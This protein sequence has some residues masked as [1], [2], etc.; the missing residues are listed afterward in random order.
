M[1]VSVTTSRCS[2]PQSTAESK[3]E[4]F[5]II[6]CHRSFVLVRNYL[7][8]INYTGPIGL[9]CD[10][11]KLFAA[12]RPYWNAEEGSHYVVG[13]TGSP[14]RIADIEEFEYQLQ[15]GCLEK[16]TKVCSYLKVL[17]ACLVNLQSPKASPL[18]CSGATAQ[19]CPDNRCG[20][21][22][23]QQDFFR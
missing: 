19:C 11:T 17:P 15:R 10:D 3:Q 14:L 13:C 23:P 22:N 9:S 2:F 4:K 21:S 16:A 8:S 18:V 20:P 12:F 1:F 7:E 5:P 6:P